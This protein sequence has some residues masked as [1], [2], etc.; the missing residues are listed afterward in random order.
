[1]V[2]VL[3][4]IT[5]LF[6]ISF[7][8]YKAATFFVHSLQNLTKD[9]PISRFFLAA[10]FIGIAT[11]LPEMFISV[12]SGFEGYPELAV[13]NALGSNITNLALV[14]PLIILFTQKSL[15]VDTESFS[16]RNAL[17][18]LSAT[19]LPFVLL[20]DRSLGFTDAVFLFFMFII[21][22]SY[23]FY[24]KHEKYGFFSLLEKIKEVFNHKDNWKDLVVIFFSLLTLILGSAAVVRVSVRLSHLLETELFVIGAVL[25]AVATSLPELLVGL[26][27]ARKKDSDIV[28]GEILGSLV[29][30]ANLVV[31]L[32]ALKKPVVFI[33]LT[34][35]TF[36]TLFLFF[37]F[38]LFYI[39]SLTQKKITKLEA[40]ILLSVYMLFVFIEYFV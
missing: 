9:R 7:V 32:A 6:I 18:I 15:K 27:A 38:V 12:L 28:F 4:N 31:G 13:G 1:M 21:Y 19:L 8:L 17:L 22:S 36:S 24:H 5:L 30:N 16:L 3:I 33:D 10:F 2:D 29:T 35:Y 23:I 11:S 20:L 34:S 40:G 37:T 39:F 25:V 14:V 26:A